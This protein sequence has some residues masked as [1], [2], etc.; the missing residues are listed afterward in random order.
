MQRALRY[1]AAYDPRQPLGAWLHGIAFRVYLEQRERWQR[2][3]RALGQADADVPTPSA[4]RVVAPDVAPLLA[5]LEPKEREALERFHLRGESIAQI[6]GAMHAA[7]G[8]VKSWLHR[9][10]HRLAA[11]ARRE[12]WL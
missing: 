9:A 5:R 8:T 2:Q 1:Q 6:A 3:P 4:R 11:A 12:D 7:E 10:R